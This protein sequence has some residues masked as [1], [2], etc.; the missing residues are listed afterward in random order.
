MTERAGGARQ[1]GPAPA[2]GGGLR[3]S[4][5]SSLVERALEE[6][7]HGPRPTDV[8]A[9]KVLGL[10]DAPPP[11]AH[12]MMTELLGGH[13]SLLHRDGV[14][15]MR[16]RARPTNAPLGELDYVVVDVETT[17]GSPRRGHRVTEIAAVQVSGGRVVGE[18][19]TLVN[20]GRP[21]PPWIQQLTGIS[22]EM[23]DDA[24]P[25]EEVCDLL[26][27]RLEGRV[28][29]AHNAPFDWRFVAHEMRR[30]RSM[31][32]EG[33]RLCTLR[34]ARRA[35]PGLRRKGL[36]AVADY[37]GVEVTRRHRAGGDALATA[38]VLVRLL[39]EADRRGVAR[40]EELQGW[41]CGG[42]PAADRRVGG[43]SAAD[44]AADTAAGSGAG[45]ARAAG[46][47]A[48]TRDPE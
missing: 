15:R 20:P 12:R 39:E 13:R 25:F 33:P 34:L 23:V 48:D 10:R 40:W 45:P 17:G 27:E 14:W 2:A 44:T 16:D 36:D 22:D 26:C 42:T 5:A 3:F 6:L 35:L 29:V 8:L 21:I 1:A 47:D 30:A 18:F 31:V 24:P 46:P 19:A 32:P 28:F 7:R 43:S 38:S 4:P 11:L 37:Y 41:L 9:R